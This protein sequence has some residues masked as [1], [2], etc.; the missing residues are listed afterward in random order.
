MIATCDK[1]RTCN[2]DGCNSK[3]NALLHV[4]QVRSY[5][6][7]NVN[8]NE[9]GR[10][11]NVV[12]GSVNSCMTGNRVYLPLVTVLVNG[13]EPAVALL[14]TGS[15]NTFIT[16]RLASKL[17]L[18]GKSVPCRLSTLGS[19]LNLMTEHVT[20]DV[21]PLNDDVTFNVRNVCVI[22]DI[23]AD[24]PAYGISLDDYSHFAGLPLSPVTNAKVDL[25]I[26]QDQPDLL[27]P[28]EICRS[29]NKAGQP[30]ATRTELGWALQGAVDDQIGCKACMMTNDIESENE[31]T[32]SWS[33]E[34][35]RVYDMWQGKTEP[36]CNMHQVVFPW[37][38]GRL[39]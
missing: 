31:S 35:Q 23:P 14:D 28:L 8:S 30:Y 6:Q 22:P 26:G 33:G 20:F 39:C 2:V 29:V 3:H 10:S 32:L 25:L 16:E 36:Q 38:P 17:S 11:P 13:R 21:S 5:T 4:N 18:Q 15:T 37:R 9:G 1:S 24:V 7:Y 12:T 34:D 19:K 27:V